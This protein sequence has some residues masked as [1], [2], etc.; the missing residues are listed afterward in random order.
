[1]SNG[2]EAVAEAV[3]E[4]AQPVRP[5]PGERLR[6]GSGVPYEDM[7]GYSRALRVDNRVISSG[8]S[9][10]GPDG[11]MDPSLKGDM[12]GQVKVAVG[13]IERAFADVG[14]TLADVVKVTFFVT[15]REQEAA[16]AFS[17]FFGPAKPAFTMV[18]V[19]FLYLPELLVE[20]EA[21][22]VVSDGAVA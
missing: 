22:A 5:K 14:A 20:V 9:A 19:A 1:M 16:R 6:A 12:Y 7:Y 4:S 13:K 17:D 10:L 11:G 21:E 18:G 8:S 15:D 3:R 2:S